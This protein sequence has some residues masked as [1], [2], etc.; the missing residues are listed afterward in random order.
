ML[1]RGRRLEFGD[2]R[3]PRNRR[4]AAIRVRVV[5]IAPS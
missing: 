3:L 1:G 4:E 2:A 5:L